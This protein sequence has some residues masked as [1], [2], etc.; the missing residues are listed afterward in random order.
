MS[1]PTA[2]HSAI[3]ARREP[4]ER[5]GLP[6]DE[7]AALA[8][9]GGRVDTAVEQCRGSPRATLAAAL[10]GFFV[11]TLDAVVVNVALPTIG[12]QLGADVSGL[13]WVVDGYTLMFAALLLSS[14]ALTDRLG[15][16]RAFGT[17]LAA[18]VVASVAC[19]VAPS[20]G[21]LV[22]ARFLQGTAA[23][24]M[25]PSSM[26]LI[27]QAYPDPARRGHAV[28]MWAMG[29]SVAA[30]SGP[31]LGG[32]LTLL[33]WRW[34]FFINVP[35]G[36]ATLAFL[37]RAAPSPHHKV[38]F[39]GAGQ[40]IAVVAM[41]SLTYGAIEAGAVG[42]SAVPV[43]VALGLAVVALGGFVTSQARGTHPMVPPRLFRSRNAVIAVVVG[44][45]F[46]AG[47]F[48]LPFVMSLYLQQHRG[49][50]SL[51]T[52]EVFLPMMLTG[53]VLTP[54]SARLVARVGARTLIAAGLV[55]MTAGLATIA[56]LPSSTPVPLL[57]VLMM[58]VGLAGPFVSPPVTAVLLDS[59]PRHLAGTASGVYNTS[60]Q[61][62]G[63]MAIAVF[64]ALL[65]QSATFMH[66]LR[67]SLLLAAG[68][69]L[70]TAVTSL[71]LR[72]TH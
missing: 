18:F 60:R 40:V 64:G 39:D 32:L 9:D 72:P 2:T 29:G 45:T 30:T 59:V 36:L 17:G 26:A 44:F 52:G 63:A 10:L 42:L 13:Q 50:S 70:A 28:A 5:A 54:F 37:A 67:A 49:L 48:G 33:S 6:A 58:L 24:V 41:G 38:P 25:M 19:G 1:D 4:V 56:V 69:S 57:S 12:R 47:Y 14:G 66:G 8:A 46:M 35:V 3:A 61:V 65:A 16:R 71:R 43:L 21:V 22:A 68:V 7:P 55:A 53:L 23:A 34:I 11:V 15:A 51:A 27:G 62:G 31:V 20:L